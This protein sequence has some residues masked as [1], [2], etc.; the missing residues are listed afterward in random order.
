MTR[1]IQDIWKR[2]DEL[3]GQAGD[4]N[5]KLIIEALKAH[6]ELM[7]LRLTPLPQEIAATMQRVIPKP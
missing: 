3:I 5:T 1:Q 2:F 7:N 6:A 4:Q